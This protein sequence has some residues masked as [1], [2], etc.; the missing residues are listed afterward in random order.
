MTTDAGKKHTAHQRAAL[1]DFNAS[2]EQSDISP[3]TRKHAAKLFEEAL[4]EAVDH[5]KTSEEVFDEWRETMHQWREY[6]REM[7]HLEQIS[8]IKAAEITRQFDQIEHTLQDFP[9]IEPKALDKAP[10]AHET[11]AP[12]P[13]APAELGRVPHNKL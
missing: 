2:L 3:S 8:A 9:N 5:R 11:A 6:L 13:G 7:R 4:Q 12:Q 1:D 10:A